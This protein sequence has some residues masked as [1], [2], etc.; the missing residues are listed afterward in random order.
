MTPTAAPKIDWYRSPIDRETL[1]TLTR[2]SDLAGFAQSAS[3]LLIYLATASLPVIFFVRGLWLPTVLACYLHSI[4]HGFV[5][6]EAAV[7]E[8]SHGTPFKSKR[9]NEFFYK[10][11]CFLTW[12]NWIHFRVSHM[13]HHQYTVY[14]AIDKEV[15]IDPI[16]FTWIDYLSWF[17]FDFRKFGKII[18]PNIAH[19]FGNG[20]YD[21]FFWDP[22]FEKD[23][24]DRRT[25][26]RW[27]RFVVIGHI[28]LA[29]L[30]IALDLWI[31]LFVVTFGSFFATFLSKGCGIQQ[32]L[33]LCPG[34]PDW[35]V[36]CHTVIFDRVTAYL[37]WQ[38]NYHIEHHMYAAVPFYHLPKLH[39]ALR[40][41]MP[42]PPKGY[43]G[44]IRRILRLARMQRNEPGYCFMPEF[45]PGA[46]PPKLA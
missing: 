46:N 8:L 40:A 27:A 7:H 22:L 44:G 18:F 28:A 16:S 35:R 30:F 9:L 11:F 3:F 1:R 24:P 17:T 20:D 34:N 15:V 37:Y 5:G 33:G 25:M 13:N 21:Y 42:E 31:L 36:I 38:M 12:N 6:M 10:T 41:D 23:S 32:H 39:R 4:F 43:L 2:R 19:F 14:R 29:V 26:I 45:P